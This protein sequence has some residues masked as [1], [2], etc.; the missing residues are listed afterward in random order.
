V[1]PAQK[2]SRIRGSNCWTLSDVPNA[3]RTRKIW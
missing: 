2:G 1:V 3:N